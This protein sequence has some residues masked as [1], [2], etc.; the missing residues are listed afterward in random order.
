[1][2]ALAHKAGALLIAAGT[3]ATTELA[4]FASTRV[5]CGIERVCWTGMPGCFR[6]LSGYDVAAHVLKH[7]RAA[8]GRC[9]TLHVLEEV[10]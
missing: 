3:Q 2:A 1:M 8:P 7:R 6:E 9:T 10:C 4:Y 5:R